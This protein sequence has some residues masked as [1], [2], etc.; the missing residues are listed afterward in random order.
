MNN[1][2]FYQDF[3][4]IRN[5]NSPTNKKVRMLGE[6]LG[7]YENFWQITG[8]TLEALKKFKENDFKRKSRMGINRSHKVDR[9]KTY[10][11]MLEGPIMDCDTWWKF[12]TENDKTVLATSSENNTNTFSKIFPIKKQDNLFKSTGFA[13][14][15]SLQEQNVLKNIAKKEGI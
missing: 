10:T 3:L 13:W 5:M 14:R 12:Y 11:T 7:S 9:H 1:E 4:A 6:M 15:H 2:Q 8:I